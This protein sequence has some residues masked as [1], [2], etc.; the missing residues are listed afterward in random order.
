MFPNMRRHLQQI[1]QERSIDILR[2]TTNAVSAN[3]SGTIN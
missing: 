3:L 2:K 1:S